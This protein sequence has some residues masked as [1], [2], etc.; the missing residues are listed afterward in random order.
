MFGLGKKLLMLWCIINALPGV[1]SL[2]LLFSGQHAP[3]LRMLF[4]ENEISLIESRALSMVDALAV[5]ANLLIVIVCSLIFIIIF[6]FYKHHMNWLLSLLILVCALIQFASYFVDVKY[7]YSQNF[8]IINGSSLF[9]LL[10]FGLCGWPQK[11][12]AIS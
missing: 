4:K 12:G 3:G 7:F 2:Y 8:W 6:R 10:G 1:F 11:R 5:L 9:L